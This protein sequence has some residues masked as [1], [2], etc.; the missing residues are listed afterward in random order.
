MTFVSYDTPVIH[1]STTKQGDYAPCVNK[2]CFFPNKGDKIDSHDNNKNNTALGILALVVHT[3]H[4][5]KLANRHSHRLPKADN[6]THSSS[7]NESG[8]AQSS[9]RAAV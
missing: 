2:T 5:A 6:P 8:Q 9:T 1:R 4:C 7:Y 3:I